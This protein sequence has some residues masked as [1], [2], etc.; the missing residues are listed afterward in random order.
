GDFVLEFP[1]KK[2]GDRVAISVSMSG[3][4]VVNWIQ[5]EVTLPADADGHE[6]TLILAREV[7]REEMA[8]RFFRLKSVEAIEAT[9]KGLVE[10]GKRDRA[11]LQRELAEA[12]AAAARAA[13]GL[14]KL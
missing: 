5:L 12:K 6:L 1:A 7:D 4:M 2:P 10:E 8:R 14:A 11:Q 13:E 9:Y 3:M